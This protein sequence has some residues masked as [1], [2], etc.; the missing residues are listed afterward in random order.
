[1]SA[2][3]HGL[4]P[5][6]VLFTGLLAG[7]SGG[8]DPAPNVQTPNTPPSQGTPGD[9]FGITSS[10]RLVSFSRTTPST[11]TAM[12]VTG[13]R[14]GENLLAI[15][16]RVAGTPAGQLYA[17]G[18]M[19]G[20]YTID[21]SSGAAT[22]KS[23]MRP[24]AAD[25][26]G[27]PPFATLIGTRVSA[28]F[29]NVV[30]Q[31]RVV[32]NTGQ[33]LRV[34]VDT[35]DTSTDAPL[36]FNGVGSIGVTEVTYTNNFASTCRNIVYYLDTTGD[37]LMTSVN[38]SAGVLTSVGSLTVDAGAQSGFDI[39]T[40]PDGTNTAFA[41]LTVNNTTSLYTVNL[42]TGAATVVGPIGQLN[43]GESILGLATPAPASTPTQPLGE[44]VALTES[45][46]LVSFNSAFPPKLC[47][48]QPVAGLQGG[49]N[50][51]SID[52]RPNDGNIYGLTSS[53]RLYT[54]NAATGTATF[55]AALTASAGDTFT[56]LNGSV[57]AD[58]S[59]GADALRV[60]S[61]TGQN[62]AVNMDTGAVITTTALNSATVNGFSVTANSY[63][64]SFSGAATS[65][66][67]N[68]DTAGDRLLTQGVT[69]GSANNPN[70]GNLSAVGNGLNIGDVQPMLGFDINALNNTALAA[71]T[72]GNATSASLYSISLTGPTPSTPGP[73]A[74]TATL[75]NAIGVN[76]RIRGL[77]Y[78]ARRQA[79]VLAITSDNRLLSFAPA[80]PGTLISNNAIT[81]MPSSEKILGFDFRP[82]NG[83]LYIL[84]TS[85]TTAQ[86][87]VYTLNPANAQAMLLSRLRPNTGDPF[88]SL[89]GTAF[90]VDFSPPADA[91]RVVSDAEHNLAVVVDSGA[92][93]TTT[94]LTR[95]AADAA[96]PAPDVVAGAYT[97]NYSPSPGTILYNIDIV[98]GRLLTQV[99]ANNG[100]LAS[101]GAL[102]PGSAATISSVAGFDIAGGQDGIAVAALVP[103]D[104]MLPTLYR[105]NLMTGA[106]TAVGPIGSATTQPLIGLTVQ[107]Q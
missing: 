56:G 12:A 36:V 48:S 104:T 66:L 54:L 72:V 19:G 74:G 17:I 93:I 28:D 8:D 49:E 25:N 107:L 81:G 29:N 75:I 82:S 98:T 42:M 76:E 35:G 60:L 64:N 33:N 2:R 3:N 86:S 39:A 5:T 52:L 45:N 32:T 61:T 97:N 105:V 73:A 10:N 15:D 92:V 102:L 88:T 46:K 90:V 50:L 57:T 41:A 26:D 77:T 87:S 53:A 62:L 14:A 91:L 16:L 37:R 9:T 22:L 40:T 100:V 23:T 96:L 69:P 101:V 68:I 80:T 71:L 20:V 6:V 70:A 34:K 103:S 24:D 78:S 47:T 94:S 30:D 7:C 27:N 95:V 44:L 18:S 79:T 55:R 59:P 51:L 99:P 106:L 21:P 65:T 11:G 43:S 89:I 58:V 83:L 13:L 67:Y 38:A 31:L 63:T 4:L 85:T 84:T 1:M